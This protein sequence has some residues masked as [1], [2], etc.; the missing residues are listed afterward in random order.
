KHTGDCD[1]EKNGMDS[2]LL[3]TPKIIV[4]HMTDLENLEKSFEYMKEPVLRE[5]RE[6]LISR[7]YDRLNV[8]V[9]YLIDR[10]GT[11]YSLMPDNY[12]GRHAMGVNHLA[13]GIENVG[14]NEK[15][16]T[17]EQ[18][19]SNVKLIRY[20]MQKYNID[21]KNIYSHSETGHLREKGSP[22]FVEKDENYFA[23][24]NCGE[25]VIKDVKKRLKSI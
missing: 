3:I 23:Q 19:D 10:D 22:Y 15:G 9:H 5:E 16:P 1:H 17:R 14:M 2:C 25:K 20:L 6:K 8:S 4:L 12:M 7:S 13:I 11:I 18:I 24:K 21:T